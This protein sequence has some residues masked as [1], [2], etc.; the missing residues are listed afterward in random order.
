MAT[1]IIPADP[2][3]IANSEAIISSIIQNG[4]ENLKNHNLIVVSP[5]GREVEGNYITGKLKDYFATHF[6]QSIKSNG[7]GPHDSINR[8]FFEI[9]REIA[10]KYGAGKQYPIV[11]LSE[12]GRQLLG[13][14]TLNLVD[15]LFYKDSAKVMGKLRTLPYESENHPETN[16][17]WGSMVL[18][19]VFMGLPEITI[20]NPYNIPGNVHFRLHLHE[21]M[22]RPDMFKSVEDYD[23]WFPENPNYNDVGVLA[24]SGQILN[25]LPFPQVQP[26]TPA[27][28]FTN[29]SEV[30]IAPMA[31]SK[32]QMSLEEELAQLAKRH[33][34]DP[35]SMMA[36]LMGGSNLHNMERICNSNWM[37]AANSPIQKPTQPLPSPASKNLTFTDPTTRT[38]VMVSPEQAESY[39]GQSVMTQGTNIPAPVAV[40]EDMPAPK[41]EEAPAKVEEAPVKEEKEPVADKPTTTTTPPVSKLSAAKRL[42]QGEKPTK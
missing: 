24:K 16:V 23:K 9:M 7:Q 31:G 6:H 26:Q 22:T 12:T 40:P 41:V 4:Q 5:Q 17:V 11:W 35:S 15:A 38:T 36:S 37:N 20:Y 39:M 27:R 33:G 28:T 29:P 34:L 42:A 8:M 3:V 19:H 10:I 25:S 1:L 18:S 2:R 14:D 30:P 13:M 21:P 32:V